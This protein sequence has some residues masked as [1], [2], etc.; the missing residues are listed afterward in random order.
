MK[1]FAIIYLKQDIR[2]NIIIIMLPNQYNFFFVNELKILHENMENNKDKKFKRKINSIF[3][4]F[5]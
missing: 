4:Y 1:F 3:V 2:I 5:T